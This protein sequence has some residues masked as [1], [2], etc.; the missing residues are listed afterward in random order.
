MAVNEPLAC[1]EQHLCRRMISVAEDL[2]GKT[3]SWPYGGIAIAKVMR[4]K[5]GIMSS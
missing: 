1:C 4:Q 2:A 5:L 3:H